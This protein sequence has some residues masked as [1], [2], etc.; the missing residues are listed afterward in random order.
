M[1]PLFPENTSLLATVLSAEETLVA[2]AGGAGVID[3]KNPSEGALGA[4][5]PSVI[6][7]VRGATPDHIHVSAALGD[8]PFLPGT[9]A[10]D[11]KSVV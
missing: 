4:P 9:A 11:R 3:V 1:N 6:S 10:L 5:A 2:V 8:M 7:A